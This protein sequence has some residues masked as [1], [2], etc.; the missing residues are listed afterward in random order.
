MQSLRAVAIVANVQ[1]I[2]IV[3]EIWVK[4]TRRSYCACVASAFC[5][6]YFILYAQFPHYC[7]STNF[8]YILYKCQCVK[9]V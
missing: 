5:S 4:H 7:I 2:R 3:H 8:R 1:S 6:M 9:R